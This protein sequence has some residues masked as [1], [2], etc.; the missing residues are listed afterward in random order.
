MEEAEHFL[1]TLLDLYF[2]SPEEQKMMK[3]L[4]AF[5]LNFRDMKAIA[6][7]CVDLSLRI[8]EQG[9]QNE[10]KKSWL[11]K[12]ANYL[13]A[14]IPK[15]TIPSNIKLP[16]PPFTP[17]VVI[18]TSIIENAQEILQIKITKREAENLLGGVKEKIK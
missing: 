15:S 8:L 14:R 6:N 17:L 12:K 1:S 10:E 18:T 5:F 7:T 2:S 11:T 4:H 13:I 3:V 16:H 9:T